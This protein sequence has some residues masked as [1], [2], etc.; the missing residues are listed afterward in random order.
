MAVIVKPIITE[1]SVT[2]AE[3]YNKYTFEV[4]GNANK[5]EAGK[6]IAKLFG[7]KVEGVTVSNRAGKTYAY[8]KSR[9]SIGSK[10]DRKLM[11]FKLKKGDKIAD[12]QI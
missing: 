4:T 8:G 12:Y 2:Q 7:V 10:P 6:E 3:K 9:R 11:V 1:K 5:T